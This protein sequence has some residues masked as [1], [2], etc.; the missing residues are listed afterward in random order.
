MVRGDIQGSLRY[1]AV[2]V[3]YWRAREFALTLAAGD[4]QPSDLVLD[5]GSPKLLATYLAKHVGCRVVATDIESY[6]IHEI[7]RIQTILKIPDDRLDAQIED[8]RR[9]GFSDDFFSKV[10]AI[11]V[12]EHI[13]EDG[14]SLCMQEIARVLAPGGRCVITVPFWRESRVDYRPPDF[15]WAAS[16]TTSADG[17][18]F[19]QRRYSEEDL[20]RR[21][22]R[23]SGLRPRRIAFVGE[24][25]MQRSDKEFCELL[26]PI[27]GP[28]QPLLSRLLLTE[29]TADWR[30]LRKPLCAL[31]VLEKS[32]L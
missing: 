10:Y 12:L 19:F 11:S 27:T 29:A 15:Y 16:S 13:P 22:L 28:I 32:N 17:Q 8:G 7:K 2:P 4:F 23:A 24:R 31:L 6:F 21:L 26:G 25:I 3:N 1:L 5:I 14:D 20:E 18:V 9:L 30:H